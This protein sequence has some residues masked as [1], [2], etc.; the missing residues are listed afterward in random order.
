MKNKRIRYREFLIIFEDPNLKGFPHPNDFINHCKK[1]NS[2]ILKYLI[3]QWEIDSNKNSKSFYNMYFEFKDYTSL[4]KIK[5]EFFNNLEVIIN[6]R[7]ESQEEAIRNC[8][9]QNK[10][11]VINDYFEFGEPKK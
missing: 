11:R 8:S 9:N 7:I 2:K 4:I 10:N 5:T 3:F 6:P 1:I